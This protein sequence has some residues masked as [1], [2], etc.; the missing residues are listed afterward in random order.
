L[1]ADKTLHCSKLA[2]WAKSG[3]EQLQQIFSKSSAGG[4]HFRPSQGL[5]N[6]AGTVD[7]KLRDGA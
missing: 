7:E 5:R 2:R 1:A 4:F 3:R 6:F